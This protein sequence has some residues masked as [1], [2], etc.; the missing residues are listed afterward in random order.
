MAGDKQRS[1]STKSTGAPK[2]FERTKPERD[3]VQDYKFGDKKKRDNKH[4]D[5]NNKKDG[6]VNFGN[7]AP[8]RG[9]M[10]GRGGDRGGRGGRGGS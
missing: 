9:G 2:S 7:S 3:P 6:A 8:S 5:K 10:R 4:S 1:K